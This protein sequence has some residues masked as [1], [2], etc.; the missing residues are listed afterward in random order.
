MNIPA[1]HLAGARVSRVPFNPAV[2][3]QLSEVKLL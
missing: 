1:I 3:T 2:N